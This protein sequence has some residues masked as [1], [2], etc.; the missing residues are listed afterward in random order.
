MNSRSR[1][2]YSDDAVNTDTA[3]SETTIKRSATYD[4]IEKSQL[5]GGILEGAIFS[6]LAMSE[7]GGGFPLP[8]TQS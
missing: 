8:D 4:V 3:F 5:Y 1:Q 2:K 6:V 7:L